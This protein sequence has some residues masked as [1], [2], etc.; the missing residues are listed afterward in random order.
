MAELK[1]IKKCLAAVRCRKE[2]VFLPYIAVTCV[3]MLAV[4]QV[5]TVHAFCVG[6]FFVHSINDE[7]IA[8]KVCMDCVVISIPIG[9]LKGHIYFC[10]IKLL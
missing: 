7:H 1:V 3:Y 2:K 4:N 6:C 9:G 10:I 5:K 8:M